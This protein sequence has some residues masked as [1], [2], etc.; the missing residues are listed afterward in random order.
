MCNAEDETVGTTIY[1]PDFPETFSLT[2][3]PPASPMPT[4][5]PLNVLEARRPE[6]IA[7]AAPSPTVA[8]ITAA[9]STDAVV[10]W[11]GT[12]TVG[13]PWITWEPVTVN[14]YPP[15]TGFT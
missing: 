7:A 15:V 2:G 6:T 5:R 12:A 9:S 8:V 10:A 11:K 13:A 1:V 4:S 3:Q 14:G